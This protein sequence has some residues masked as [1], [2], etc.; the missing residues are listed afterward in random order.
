MSETPAGPLPSLD[1]LSKFF[2]TAGE[3]G[4]LRFQRC[5]KCSHWQHPP[6]VI[7]AQCSSAELSEQATA[8]SATVLAASIN[9]Q[10][11]MPGLEVPYALA[12]VELDEQ[13]GL[14]LTTR[15][16][17]IAPQEVVIGQRMQ[18]RF[19]HRED[20]WLPLFAPINS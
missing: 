10:P 13:K 2:W 11:W 14:R 16:V 1:G 17:D 3:S 12:I 19:E 20:V 4:E 15:I 9:Y 6:S 8:G 7:C 5:D 18:V